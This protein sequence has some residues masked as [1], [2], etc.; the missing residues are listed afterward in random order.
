MKLSVIIPTFNEAGNIYKTIEALYERAVLA[1]YEIIVVDCGSSD[2]TLDC[3]KRKEVIT[4]INPRL[5]GKKCRSLRLG[6]NIA[7]GEVLLFLDADTLVPQQY[8]AKIKRAL[9]DTA[10][11]GGAFEFSLDKRSIPLF[12]VTLINRIRYR[13]RKRFYGDQGIFVRKAVYRKAGG[14][15]ERSLLEAAYLCKSLQKLGKLKLI[16]QPVVTSSRRFTEGGVWRVLL[17]DIRI[18]AMDLFGM[19]VEHYGNAYWA[20][21]QAYGVEKKALVTEE[22][23]E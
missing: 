16:R 23:P 10:V 22:V 21:N 19:N 3:I 7:Q 6:T 1:P 15:P 4:I 17:H 2:G 12:L 9:Q 13:F 18:W 8:D 11:V 20:K 5:S 14:W